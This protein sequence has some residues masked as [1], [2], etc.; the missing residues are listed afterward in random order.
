MLTAYLLMNLSPSVAIDF[1]TPFELCSGKPGNYNNLKV[2]GCH[3]YAH[4]KQGKLF[5]RALKGQFIGYPDCVKGYKLWCTNLTPP[6]CI[7]S[8]DVIFNEG[9]VL[10]KRP[11]FKDVKPQT[12]PLKIVLFGVEHSKKKKKSH[13]AAYSDGV[14]MKVVG[15]LKHNLN[16]TYKLNSGI[17]I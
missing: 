9:S 6:K 10:V 1:K 13:E 3:A 11:P 16:S 17:I 12:K 8:G 5:L 15:L 14:K 4:V 2:F 7:I